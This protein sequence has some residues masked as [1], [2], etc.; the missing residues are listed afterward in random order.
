[1]NSDYH[2]AIQTT[3]RQ[4]LSRVRKDL[5][6]KRYRTDRKTMDRGSSG[7]KQAIHARI[8]CHGRASLVRRVEFLRKKA[9]TGVSL[10]VRCIAAY[11]RTTSSHL[12]VVSAGNSQKNSMAVS[13]CQ[14]ELNNVTSTIHNASKRRKTISEL[15]ENQ[16]YSSSTERKSCPLSRTPYDRKR[17]WEFHF[18][19]RQRNC[20]WRHGNVTSSQSGHA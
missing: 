7:G 8:T 13:E 3:P 5:T 16:T 19:A 11:R 4:K 2:Y 17:T 1:M 20:G 18:P 6:R 12:H 10:V 14:E 15:Q 9:H